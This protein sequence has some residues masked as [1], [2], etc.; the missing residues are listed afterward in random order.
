MSD[1]DVAALVRE[2]VDTSD[3]TDPTALAK[4][5]ADRIPDADTRAAL[6]Q[7]L[8]ALVRREFR[9]YNEQ[10]IAHPVSESTVDQQ[11]APRASS[12]VTRIRER[13]LSDRIAGLDGYKRLGDCTI[14]D[15]EHAAG[16]REAHARAT[17]ARAAQLRV[18]AGLLAEHKVATVRE[19]P[20]DALREARGDD[21]A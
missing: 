11:P 6:E 18:L 9:R 20:E 3:D 1:I 19:L 7:T 5:V 14:A 8:P 2:V 12:K 21:A 10:W 13:W 4:L 17:F 16:E 15:L